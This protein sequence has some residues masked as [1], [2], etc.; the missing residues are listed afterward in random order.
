MKKKSLVTSIAIAL[1]SFYLTGCNDHDDQQNNNNPIQQQKPNVLFIMADDL[2]YSDLG[3]FGGEIHTR[4]NKL[5]S[6]RKFSLDSLKIIRT[7][8]V[9]NF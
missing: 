5:Y 1:L 7:G 4:S 8:I 3:S 6:V 2:G 9:L